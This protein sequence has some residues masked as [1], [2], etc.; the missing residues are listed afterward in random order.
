MA[1][2]SFTVPIVAVKCRAYTTLKHSFSVTFES[3][4]KSYAYCLLPKK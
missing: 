3:H 4:K 1:A 2:Q